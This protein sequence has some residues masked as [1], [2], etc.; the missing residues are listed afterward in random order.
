MHDSDTDP[1]IGSSAQAAPAP[2]LGIAASIHHFS[3]G[4]TSLH[5][6]GI[7]QKTVARRLQA[8]YTKVDRRSAEQ[9][10]GELQGTRQE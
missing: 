4:T 6:P 3:W 8:T 7:S 5:S 2:L 1:G 10:G 9:V